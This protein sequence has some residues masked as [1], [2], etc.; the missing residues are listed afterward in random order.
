MV[1]S[2][3]EGILSNFGDF[4]GNNPAENSAANLVSLLTGK[5]PSDVSTL[6]WN[7]SSMA[8]RAELMKESKT[9]SAYTDQIKQTLDLQIRI[10]QSIAGAKIDETPVI[11]RG[12]VTFNAEGS[13]DPK[14]PYFSRVLHWPGGASGVTIG[15][16]YDMKL[17]TQ[18]QVKSDLMASGVSEKAAV[19]FASG[20]GLRGEAAHKFVVE[21]K[22]DFG[23][24]DRDAE[25]NLFN[26]V[27]PKY[28]ADAAT[29][30]NIKVRQ[31]NLKAP[32]WNSLDPKI[33]EIVVDMTF[34]QGSIFDR[35]MKAIASNNKDTLANYINSAKDL[36]SYEEGR[37]R[38]DYLL[39]E[40]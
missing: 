10:A 30:Y 37:H 23:K 17:R 9:S 22:I 20:A 24:I 4:P 2:A 11:K 39:S 21:N 29:S 6:L 14:S 7:K 3:S 25:I 15:R 12:H 16:G 38:S 13:N 27:Y 31:L 36:R 40:K 5:A 33:R 35:Q 18:E 34:Q 8:E 28:E 32:A 26:K 1:R 19:R